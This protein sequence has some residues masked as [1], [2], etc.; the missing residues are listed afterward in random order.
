MRSRERWQLGWFDALAFAVAIGWA[1][2]A[3]AEDDAAALFASATSALHD[4]RAGDAIV[5]LEALAD[6]GVV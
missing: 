4:G 2:P 1:G 6:R 5:A 3:R